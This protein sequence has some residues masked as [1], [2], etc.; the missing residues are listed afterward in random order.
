MSSDRS[1][2]LFARRLTVNPWNEQPILSR[3]GQSLLAG[4]YRKDS[5]MV[6]ARCDVGEKLH[7]R[8]TLKG[9]SEYKYC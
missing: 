9:L 6:R 5:V 2:N 4:F 1:I 7:V 8:Y 3:S